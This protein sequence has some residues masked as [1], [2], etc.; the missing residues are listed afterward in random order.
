MPP[1]ASE[2]ELVDVLLVDVAGELLDAVVPF[3]AGALTEDVVHPFSLVDSHLVPMPDDLV[4]AAWEWVQDPGSVNLLAFY[5]AEEGELVPETPK[6][7]KPSPKRSSRARSLDGGDGGR[8]TVPAK[9]PTVAQLAVSLEQV[10]Q[11]L[12]MMVEQLKML[13]DR[14]NAIEANLQRGTSRPSALQQPLGQSATVGSQRVSFSPKDLVQ[15]FPPPR[16]S[17]TRGSPPLQQRTSQAALETSQLEEEK[18]V[19]SGQSDF[20]TIPGIDNSCVAAGQWGPDWRS[21]FELPHAVDQRC[22]GASEVTAGTCSQSRVILSECASVY[23][24]ANATIPSCRNESSGFDGTR[25]LPNCLLGKIRGL[26]EGERSWLPSVAGVYAARPF[27]ERQ[28]QR[29]EGHSSLVGSL[30]RAE[31]YGWWPDGHR[32][33]PI[34]LRGPPL[35]GI[36][37]ESHDFL[38]KGP[39]IRTIG[40]TTLGDHSTS[41]H[42][43]NGPDCHEAPR[44]NWKAWR[45]GSKCPTT[46]S[47]EAT[48]EGSKGKRKAR[49]DSQPRGGIAK[50]VASKIRDEIPDPLSDTPKLS[51]IVASLPRWILATRTFFSSLLFRTFHI[52]PGSIAP[53]TVVFPIPVPEL[54]LFRSG[55]PKLSS[56]KWRALI[57]KRLLHIVVVA[58][59]F[60]EGSLNMQN[61]HLLG[62]HPNTV[63]RQIHKRLR[64]LLA[65]CDLSSQDPIPLIPGRSGHEFISSVFHLE[66]FAKKHECL[67]PEHYSSG[68]VDFEKCAFGSA[69]KGEADDAALTM[70]TSLN[71]DR[72]R[73]VGTGAWQT[74][75]HLHD[76]L[77]LPYVEPAVLRHGASIDYSAG[78]NLQREDPAEY[79]K[80]ARKWSGLGLLS[81]TDEPPHR[82]TFTRIF[83]CYKSAEADR[84][85]GDRRLANAAEYS[86]SGPSR[87][88]PA[89]YHLVNISVP[90]GHCVFGSITDRKDFYHQCAATDSRAASNVIPFCFAQSEFVGDPALKHLWALKTAR[91][92]DRSRSGDHLGGRMHSVF[93]ESSKVY[94]CFRSLLQGDHLG[95]EFALSAHAHLLEAAGV[96]SQEKRVQGYMPFPK[97]PDYQILVIDD[98]VSLSVCPPSVL[99]HDASCSQ[100]LKKAAIAYEK[101]AVIGSTEKDIHGSCHFKAIGAEVNSSKRLRDIGLSTVAAPLQK[102]IAV[103]TLALRVAQLSVITPT[104]AARLAGNFTSI[105]M[106]RRCLTCVLNEIYQYG[107]DETGSNDEVFHLSRSTAQELVLASILSFVAVSDVTAKFTKKVYASD[108]SLAKGAYCSR[109]ISLATAQVLW[110]GGDKKGTY[111]RL[112][113]P[114]RELGKVAGLDFDKEEAAEAEA[115]NAR[116]EIPKHL[117]FVFDFLEICAGV[118]SISKAVARLGYRVCTPIELS[119]SPAFDITSLDL[120]NWICN[121]LRSGRLKSIMVEPV[122]TTFSAAAHPSVRSY[123]IPKGFDPS[124]PKTYLGNKIAFHCLFLCWYAALCQCPSL[125]EQPRLSKMCWLSIW[126]FLQKNFG[127]SESVVASCQFGSC[128]R[129]EFRMLSKYIDAEALETR[130]PGGHEH[131]RIE[132]KFTKSS[133]IYTPAL[134]DHI[135]RAFAVALRR[136]VVAEED[137]CKVSGL[138]SVVANDLLMTGKWQVEREWTWDKPSHINV[139]ESNA[140]IAILRDQLRS[141]GDCRFTSLLDS[142]VA[143]GAHAKGR[144][145]AKTLGPSLRRGAAFQ[146]AGGLYPSLG[147]APTRL[148]TADAPTRDREIRPHRFGGEG[149]LI[150][151]QSATLNAQ[152][153]FVYIAVAIS[154]LAG[155]GGGPS[156]ISH[157]NRSPAG[158]FVIFR[159]FFGVWIWRGYWDGILGR[160]GGILGLEK[161]RN[162]NKILCIGTFKR[163]L[164]CQSRKTHL[165]RARNWVVFACFLD[166]FC[167][168]EV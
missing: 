137:S 143:K 49:P 117:D 105:F 153:T 123:K 13:T 119:D 31:C 14:Q 121:M 100:D 101:E 162:R 47:Q 5:S 112:Q 55:N 21:V 42:Q 68:P 127:F 64:M 22:P 110:L 149:V 3:A 57:R 73:L 90:K 66:S 17:L 136:K 128:H 107:C 98:F 59:N 113:A 40:R 79:L 164:G 20:G 115:E 19:D 56:K 76:E 11:T 39:G 43:R 168:L 145:S 165:H 167:V 114:F 133:A 37:V 1:Q 151:V 28:H 78:P 131:I 6:T 72:L 45:Q 77:W 154:A 71:A 86:I 150:G 61:V 38:C 135:A 104:L 88:L 51:K 63:H 120:V 2:G 8:G 140:Y 36:P 116:A 144:S 160:F 130:C 103:L 16:S 109:D 155:G 106:F 34:P 126:G 134:A 148:N 24:P 132:G 159:T 129:K 85:I 166:D 30:H 91:K 15:E 146:I 80:L 7:E 163:D 46:K 122:C 53:E 158:V 9:R 65:T 93:D 142:R 82:D 25:C 27:A 33:A 96:L 75:D 74:Q 44:C 12:P 125:C 29:G 83:N 89:G 52:L 84:Q 157:R 102:R 18:T 62:R 23:G 87:Y 10:N 95:V 139:L 69:L 58:L 81:L 152:V 70:Y 54:G 48:K 118:G 32:D 60:I 156:K 108:A 35:R 99:S 111:T 94:P 67:D 41:I 97:G 147:F 92:N 4:N 161:R 141:G 138:E 124:S 50:V 26:W